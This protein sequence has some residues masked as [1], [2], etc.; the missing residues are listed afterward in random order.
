MRLFPAPR[1]L[2][3][4]LAAIC[5]PQVPPPAFSAPEPLPGHVRAFLDSHC[6][7]CH[8]SSD[9]KGKVNLEISAL[10][11]ALK[12]DAELLAHVHQALSK[13]E[14]PPKK[15]PRP[16]AA[17]QAAILTWIDQA[18]THR[19][20]PH[21]TS[22][23]R[24]NRAEFAK[25][26]TQ[27]FALPFR[28]PTGFP[29]DSRSHGFDNIAES[30]SLSPP[31][32]EAYAETATE[33]ADQLFPPPPEPAPPS[34]KF[35]LPVTELSSADGYG[36]SSLVVDDKMRLV[37]HNY[38]SSTS[39][40]GAQASGKYRVR[41]R[42]SAVHAV[43]DQPILLT[44]GGKDFPLPA[45]GI[46]EHEFTVTLHPGDGVG[47]QF[48]TAAFGRIDAN[49]PY[50]EV[51]EDLLKHF[52]LQPRHVAA[53][54]SLHEAAPD[55]PAG[56]LRLKP[57]LSKSYE[58]RKKTIQRAFEEEFARPDL[59]LSSATP[60][61]TRHLV[62]AML[63]DKNPN[64]FGGT[65]MHFYVLPLVWKLYADGPAV[66]ILS[67]EIEGP[68]EPVEHFRFARA[69]T[70]QTNLLGTTTARMTTPE[71][72][73]AALGRMLGK[74]FRRPPSAPELARYRTLLEGHRNENHSLEEAFHL[75]LRTALISPQFLYRGSA[76][77]EA[78][79][80]HQIASRLSYFLT[81]GPPDEKLLLAAADGSLLQPETLRAQANRLLSEKAA[82]EFIENFVGQWLGT[83]TIPEI[84]PDA[85]LGRFGAD[86]QR[87]LIKEP[88]QL[89][90]EILR[91]NGP[92]S[93][94]IDP[95]FTHTHNS[96]G[97]QMYG[98]DLP[99]PNSK[100][101]FALTRVTFPKGERIG[102]LLG[103]AGVMMATA[104]GVDTQPVLRGKWF[105][106]NIL[107]EAPPPPPESVPA[108]TPDTRGT[109]TIRDLMR[110]HT[111]EES[112][113][114]CHSK[115]DPYGFVFESFDAIGQHRDRYPASGKKKQEW[116]PV[117]TTATLPDGTLLQ[118]SAGLKRHLL[119]DLRP[120]AR[121]LAEKLFLYGT[122]RLPSYAERKA[123]GTLA[124]ESLRP[125]RGL[126]DLLLDIVSHESFRSR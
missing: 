126:H 109:K 25:T 60:E 82:Q 94:F 19:T 93:D 104:N 26:L 68:I 48:K 87:S 46:A 117:D 88:E 81:L 79:S 44:A 97:R 69:R 33:L 47:F 99:P 96:V 63:V 15:K 49:F 29:E 56:T 77:E 101:P 24:L 7:D 125:Q 114:R 67:L 9:P 39:K 17:Q 100:Q 41:F 42:A 123:L 72:V 120:F 35:I 36:P 54:L 103:M 124:D 62:D 71:A 108:I 90:A 111:S 70:H 37:F 27:T 28:I 105:L 107:G 65:E 23:R 32:L 22:L 5:L 43:P 95:G 45:E 83:R 52:A 2:C 66:D 57:F 85:S 10:D 84:M 91:D 59:D 31:L 106:E 122:G 92:L 75:A 98:L 13:G 116:A 110:A 12:T 34:Q 74:L 8:D 11:L 76:G 58:L 115:L 64:G 80:P 55:S 51:R 89:F 73:E 121:C 112:C 6:A 118:D 30:L 86:H 4:L 16:P 20:P 119:A 3:A 1:R 113:A 38:S 21:A 78:L 61:A 50:K 14:M 40:F 53:W 18:L 102:G